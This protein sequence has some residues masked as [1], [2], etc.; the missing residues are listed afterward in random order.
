M[1]L[2]LHKL[3]TD[4]TSM[5]YHGTPNTVSSTQLKTILEDPK[6]FYDKYIA[7]TIDKVEA[8]AFDIGSY[9]HTAVLEPHKL[10]EEVVIYKGGHRIGAK[11]EAFKR[12]HTGKYILTPAQELVGKKLAR[13]VRSSKLCRKYLKGTTNEVSLFV[14]LWVYDND[15]IYAP[16]FKKYL[17]PD[18]WFTPSKKPDG[19]YTQVIVKVRADSLGDTFMSDLKSTSSDVDSQSEMD[20]AVKMY[21]YELSA[22]LYFD[23][24]SLLRPKLHKWVWIFSSKGKESARPWVCSPAK[25]KAGRAR[26]SE[27]VIKYA[28]YKRSNW[29][30][31][32]VEGVIDADQ[33]DYININKMEKAF[34]GY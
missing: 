1:K 28:R 13:A 7:K 5:E 12:E 31:E 22:A 20:A 27:A 4:M 30:F 17:T 26:W 32:Y 11:W 6:E 8:V 3:I 18:G 2:R 25:L 14:A 9:F 34:H 10:K 19:N 21:S 15:T 33:A 16:K 23:M 29:K 24:F